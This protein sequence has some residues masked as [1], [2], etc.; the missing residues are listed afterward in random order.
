MTN[1][2][3]H[4]E[5]HGAGPNDYTKL[6]KEMTEKGFSQTVL[7]DNAA[8]CAFSPAE[9]YLQGAL[10]RADVLELAAAAAAA[11]MPNYNVRVVNTTGLTWHMQSAVR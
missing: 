6:H 4:I 5:L 2:F 3:T 10:T 11:V 9:Y 1:F 7:S 8:I